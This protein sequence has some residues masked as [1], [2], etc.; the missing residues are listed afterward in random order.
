MMNNRK[1]AE[2]LSNSGYVEIAFREKLTDS[3]YGYVALSPELNGCAVQGD[4]IKE[5]RENLKLFRVDYIEHLL[6]HGLPVPEP[7]SPS[8]PV[9]LRRV[10]SSSDFVETEGDNAEQEV[11]HPAVTLLNEDKVVAC[12]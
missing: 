12:G 8:K 4:T 9:E 5:A 11:D 2:E 10:M 1:H 3:E 7:A 6:D